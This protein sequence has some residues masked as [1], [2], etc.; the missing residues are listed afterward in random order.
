MRV[1]LLSC[2]SEQA[3]DPDNFACAWLRES[4]AQDPFGKHQVT[5]DP[6]TADLILFVEAHPGTDPFLLSVMDHPLFRLYP[7]KVFLYHD[8]DHALP[9]V[10]GIYPSI[11]RRDFQPERCRS[12]G[13]I[14]RISQNEDIR[15]DP[16][17]VER[18]WLY[19]F[20]GEANSPERRAIFAQAHPHGWVRDTTGRRHWEMAEGSPE[21]RAFTREFAD[22][23]RRSQFVLCP[24]GQGPTSYRLFETMEMGRV[25]VIICDE[26]VP[27]EGPRWDEFSIQLPENRIPDLESIL[28]ENSPRHEEMGRLA[29]EAWKQH[30]AKEVSFHR[31]TEL[32]AEL[33]AI[34]PSLLSALRPWIRLL[35]SRYFKIWLRPKY[36]RLRNKFQR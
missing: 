32:C 13:Y 11:L 14:A 23:I 19:S 4:A 6:A 17:P 1:H 9:F 10:R 20:S 26:W 31:M 15:Y 28:L 7:D 24:G 34:R 30:F 25:P 5:E 2:F 29:R 18:Q 21:R 22:S 35:T 33:L 8:A 3:P 12:G 16:A 27:I 36:H